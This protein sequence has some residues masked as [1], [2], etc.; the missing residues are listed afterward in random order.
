MNVRVRTGVIVGAAVVIAIA[1]AAIVFALNWPF[2]RGGIEKRLSRAV[3]GTVQMEAFHSHWFP[4]PGCDAV[5]VQITTPRGRASIQRIVV[6]SSYSAFLR[7]SENLTLLLIDGLSAQLTQPGLS[8]GS[9]GGKTSIDHLVLNHSNIQFEPNNQGT[10]RTIT[11]TNADIRNLAPGHTVAFNVLLD[12]AKPRGPLLISGQY[13]PSSSNQNNATPVSGKFH[14]QH[15]DLSAFQSLAGVIDAQGTF[16]GPSGAIKVNGKSDI[17]NFKVGG[18]HHNAV[19]IAAKLTA[20][21]NA[22]NADTHLD[23]VDTQFLDTDIHW[24]GD[25]AGKNG[26]KTTKLELSSVHARVQDLLYLISQSPRPALNGPISFRARA[27]L[28]PSRAPFLK[29]IELDGDFAINNARF[30]TFQTQRNVALLSDRAQGEKK[31]VQNPESVFS[32][33]AGH[34]VLRNG[35][36]HVSNLRFHVPGASAQLQGTYNVI[37]YAVNLHGTLALEK[38]LSDATTGVKSIVLKIVD[39]FFKRRNAGAVIPVSITGTYDHPIFTALWKHA[40]QNTASR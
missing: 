25:I 13:G 9:G 21:V 3:G 15:A 17:A 24:T 4:H 28:P 30:Q 39:P 36:A 34:V 8:L 1:A 31:L 6:R 22:T 19:R 33:I 26:G 35:D 7:H 12:W 2:T 14:L 5:N 16:S 29:K 23:S 10:A 40:S 20:T 18:R 38:D 37:H 11:I 27:T 32:D